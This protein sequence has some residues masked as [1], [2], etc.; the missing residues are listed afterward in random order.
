MQTAPVNMQANGSPV[1][2]G[3]GP[4]GRPPQNHQQVTPEAMQRFLA[5]ARQNPTAMNSLTQMMASQGQAQFPA[6]ATPQQREALARFAQQNRGG[7]QTQGGVAAAAQ[8]VAQTQ[9]MMQAQQQ[10]ALGNGGSP[11]QAQPNQN[12]NLPGPR[13]NQQGVQSQP[14]QVQAQTQNDNPNQGV[15]QSNGNI[16][17]GRAPPPGPISMPSQAGQARPP[18][19]AAGGMNTVPNPNNAQQRPNLN[20]QA[21]D[22]QLANILSNL[23]V[24]IQ[25]KENNQLGPEETKMVSTLC[26]P[27]QA[28]KQ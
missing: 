10:Q 23:D 8:L 3:P 13:P 24:F 19:P 9:R 15:V 4:N 18:V 6:G 22:Q 26:R 20:K 7:Q 17:G 1:I 2:Q 21:L 14:L 25:K 16:I 12:G 11:V 5:T 27:C 28:L